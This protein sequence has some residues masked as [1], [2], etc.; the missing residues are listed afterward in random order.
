MKFL[1]PVFVF[2]LITG[3]TK[4]QSAK[5]YYKKGIEAQKNNNCKDAIRNFNTAIDLKGDFTEAY[6]QRAAC[7]S[8]L[9][10]YEQALHDYIYLHRITPLNESYII[11]AALTYMNLKRYSDAQNMLMK[12]EADDMN[13][14][15]AEAKVK[16][17]QCKIMLKNYEEAVQYLT[18]SLSIFSN[19]DQIYFYKGVASDSLKDYQ[20]ALLC[21]TKSIELVNEKWI[22]KVINS[23]TNDSLTFIY[24]VSLGKAQLKMFDYAL[25][26]ETIS[27]AIKIKPKEASNY[28]L[29]A[30]ICYQVNELN[31][32]LADL[33]M[34]E[35]LN[36]K[37]YEY[38]YTK[39]RV[40]K[41]AGQF[42]QAIENLEP[43]VKSDTAFY[44][45][46]LKGQCLES[47]GK[48]EE[49][50]TAYS[51]ANK[52]V[53][54][55]KVKEMEAANKRIRN[56]VYELKRESD[57]PLL[58][59]GSPALDIDNKIMVPKSHQF[60][61]IKGKIFDKSHIKSI[62][63]NDME[64]DFAVD[65]LNPDFRIK[66]N[67]LDKNYLKVK[68]L[69]VYSNVTEQNF[70]FN[71][72]E[73]NAPK[74]KL[75]LSCS[76]TNREVFIDKTINKTIKVQGRVDDES[77]IKRIMINNKTA[78]FNLNESNPS[79]EA[80]IEILNTDSIKILI[81]D[82][83]DNTT[84]CSYYI[85]SKKAREMAQNPMGKT[86]LVFIANSNYESFTTLTGPVKDMNMIRNAMLQYN[87]DNIITRQNLT[88]SEM[89]KFLRI[90]LRDMIKE[91]QVQSLLI[92]FAGHGKYVNET[93]YWL[94]VNAKKDDELSY[95]PIPYLKSNLTGYSKTLKN[96]LVISDACES[97]P[98]FSLSDESVAVFDCN[99]QPNIQ[100]NNSA[101]VFSSTTNEK[102]SD[103]SVFCESFADRLNTNQN[104]CIS[105]SEMVNF[106]STTV[107][108]R[109]SQ[110]CKYGKI[111]D[112]GS[113]TG[114]FYF[115][116]RSQ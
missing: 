85:N 6:F 46:F 36:L 16:M 114:C 73:K 8:R 100:N 87:I 32:A 3:I 5:E 58:K 33:K 104:P 84:A 53:P 91:Q 56:R 113:N 48:F 47:V 88:L 19:E 49:A 68:V 24:L 13:L 65:S 7:Y 89:E 86:W 102:A 37:S 116:K 75:F 23:N 82:E 31:E 17:A 67:L 83:Y 79:F 80:E 43:I 64:A 26:K 99:H 1:L 90:E 34:C 35:G 69:D 29:R 66:V 105:M 95:Y 44:A 110:R 57:P 12:L 101:Y 45:R 10:Q 54:S 71:R 50:Q 62:S 77:F 42:H 18:E 61:E 78:S 81:I 39:A 15:I 38:Y 20:A 96:I 2:L 93:G 40:L 103:N 55:D 41:K 98:S 74:Y 72:L 22:K 63:L 106:V 112:I 52:K 60:V 107:E 4:A 94:P 27:K 30:L 70:E 14:H 28:L 97:G 92:W 108:K 21:Y 109:Q 11:K 111:K 115:L 25:A 76:E 9:N 59:I 51:L